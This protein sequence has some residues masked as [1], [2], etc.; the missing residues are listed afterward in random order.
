M[1]KQFNNYGRERKEN[2]WKIVNGKA[3][4]TENLEQQPLSDREVGDT[5][6]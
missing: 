1:H 6:R 3:L 2:T 4:N 5:E